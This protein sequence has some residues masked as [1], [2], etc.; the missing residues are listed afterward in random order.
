MRVALI[1]LSWCCSWSAL[2]A[3]E[4]PHAFVGAR[5]VPIEG[6]E[7]AS[8]TLLTRAGKIVAVGTHDELVAS[9]EL[10]ARFCEIQF[11]VNGTSH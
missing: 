8:G 9:N 3:Q 4:R 11:A 2:P 10:Y 1:V 5:I 6:A 7:I